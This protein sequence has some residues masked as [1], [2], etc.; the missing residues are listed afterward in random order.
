MGTRRTS[1]SVYV[2]IHRLVHMLSVLRYLI[3]LCGSCVV[4]LQLVLDIFRFC[5]VISY[6]Y[7]QC[8]CLPYTLCCTVRASEHSREAFPAS[9]SVH[10]HTNTFA[11]IH[12]PQHFRFRS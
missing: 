12:K 4:Y 1:E 3:Y 8:V 6:R 10:N 5:T 11:P 2:A 7:Q 9:S